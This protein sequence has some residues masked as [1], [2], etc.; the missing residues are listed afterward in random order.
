MVR[1]WNVETRSLIHTFLG[2]NYLG[3]DSEIKGLHFNADGNTL[4]GW[5]DY[6]M[7]IWDIEKRVFERDLNM[8]FGRQTDVAF[9]SDRILVV[10]GN[11]KRILYGDFNP[12]MKGEKIPDHKIDDAHEKSITCV[13]LSPDGK[14][15]AS[16]SK[17]KSIRLWDAS[18]KTLHKTLR[19]HR[20]PIFGLTFSSDGSSIASIS[21]DKTVRVWNVATGRRSHTFKTHSKYPHRIS[22]SPNGETLASSSLPGIIHQ[23]D[24]NKGKHKNTI[25]GHGAGFAT[26]SVVFSK[27]KIT[28]ATTDGNN[29]II[30]Y[31]LN[32]QEVQTVLTGHKDLVTILTFS[33]NG[34][35]LASGGLDKTIRLWTVATGEPKKT[36]RGHF[37]LVSHIMF[38][39]NETLISYGYDKMVRQ[40]DVIEGRQKNSFEIGGC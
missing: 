31:D 11:Y 32:T 33:P 18:T 16:G 21:E 30:L 26:K 36:L 15:I 28:G 25:V 23:W 20:R 38:K 37:G 14:M 5:S 34:E 10:D 17:D 8:H 19:G 35:T 12:E 3:Y 1:L 39:D 27:D 40:W 22:F 2:Y 13:S 29:N 7:Y 24:L 4:M 9:Q 6:G